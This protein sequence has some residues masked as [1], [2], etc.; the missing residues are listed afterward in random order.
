MNKEVN[1]DQGVGATEFDYPNSQHPGYTNH[2]HYGPQFVPHPTNNS[3]K[4]VDKSNVMSQA[5]RG[6]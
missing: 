5:L 1:G 3:A 2:I 4:S 6:K